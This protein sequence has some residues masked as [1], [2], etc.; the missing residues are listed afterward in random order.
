MTNHVHEWL[1]AYHDG[2]LS[3]SQLRKVEAHLAECE[4][5]RAKLDELRALS[6]LLQENPAASDLTPPDRFVAQVGLRLSRRPERTFG[7]KVLETIWQL[8]PVGLLGT[9][10]FMQTALIVTGVLLVVMH[11]AGKPIGSLLPPSSGGTWPSEPTTLTRLGELGFAAWWT[12][13]GGSALFGVLPLGVTLPLGI[14]LL[15]WSWLAT[16]WIRHR[17]RQQEGQPARKQQA[18]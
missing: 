4:T 12:L 10:T 13:G 5:C 14:V 8:L 7:Q 16:W 6:A 9:W 17:H 1:A 15:Y 11:L 18:S 2:E 3:G